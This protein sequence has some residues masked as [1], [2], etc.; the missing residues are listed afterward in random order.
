MI[1]IT[2]GLGF[3]GT[4]TARAL[5]DLGESVVLVQR[6]APEV[7]APLAGQADGR[8]VVEQADLT[9]R[10]ALLG[11]GDRHKITGIVH[12]A[13]SVPWPPGADEP[14]E[15]VRK[16]VAGLLNVFHAAAEWQ[17]SRLGLASTIGVY[18]GVE[19]PSPL[20]ED[21]PLPMTAHHPIPT[22]KKIGELVAGHLAG[23][24]GLDVVNL[25]IGAIWGPLGHP[26]SPFFVLPQL[27]HAAVRGEVPDLTSP[28][29]G[30]NAE[31]GG[32][33]CYV[34]DCGRA[35]ALLQVADRLRHRTYNVAGGRMTTNGEVAEAIG[36]AVPGARVELREGRDPAGPGRDLHLDITR[37]REDTG[38]EPAYDTASGIADYVS[39]LRAGNAR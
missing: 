20:A 11:L 4:H 35:I 29:W 12:L 27:V 18:G 8:L 15:G 28:A 10:A 2:G 38:F 39:W 22:F 17:V 19:A 26:R 14:V 36:R 16:S 7:T 30:A 13:G 23:A 31:D 32:D 3:I 25:R 1:L 24:T 21:L 5:L 37:L 6:R 9:D 33:L 34:K